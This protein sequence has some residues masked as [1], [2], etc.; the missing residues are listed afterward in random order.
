MRSSTPAMQRPAVGF[1][2]AALALLTL[3]ALLR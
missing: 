1:T 3:L 2:I